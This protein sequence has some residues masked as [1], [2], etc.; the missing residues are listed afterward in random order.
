MTELHNRLQATLGDAF[1]LERELARGGMSRLF[2]ATEASLNRQ[3]VIKVL[4][5]E[6]A[7]DV[8]AARFKQEI[9]LAAQLQHPHILPVLTAG[10]QD[11]LIYY[12]M[13]YVTGESLRHRLTT[14]GKLPVT[15]AARIL[16][17]V[18]DALA[19]AHAHGVVHRD[20]KPEN[21]LL[22]QGHAVLTDFGVARALAEARGEERLTE[23]GL[24]V[25]TPGYMAP[26][27]VA[28]ERHVDARADVYALAVVGY[29][30]LA[31]TPPFTGPTAQAVLAAHLTETPKPLSELRADTPPA[32]TTTIAQALAKDP[33]ERLQTAA[34]FRDVVGT[35][36]GVIAAIAAPRRWL[37]GVAA[38]AVLVLA[39]VFALWPRGW[40]IEG[41]PRKSI[42]VFPFENRTGIADNDWLQEASMN[43]LDLSLAHWEDMRVYDDERTAS[44]MR[45][46]DVASPQDLDFD[47]AQAMAREARVGTLVLGDIRRE[48]DSLVVEAKVHDVASG[49]RLAT[50]IVRSD[51][52]SDPR[53]LF[54]S[55]AARILQVSGAP[56]GERPGVVAQTTRSL[57]AYRAYLAGTD[58]LQRFALDSAEMHLTRAVELD[59]TFA[60]TY[61]QLRNVEGWR[62]A[63]GDPAKR[64]ALV[65][66]AAA[67]SQALPSRLR[68]L[69]QAYAAFEN[70]QLRRSRSIAEQLIAR[71]PAD[72]EAWYQLGEAHY[73]DRSQEFPHP[74]T[75]GNVGKALHAFQRALALDSNY[76]LA[77]QHILD[78]L[79][80]CADAGASY[81]CFADSALYAEPAALRARFGAETVER[82]RRQAEEERV[83]TAYGW[84]SA[85]PSS[86][87]AREGLIRLLLDRERFDEAAN[88]STILKDLGLESQ[89]LA[90]EARA[91]FA[92]R[93]FSEAADRMTESTATLSDAELDA[94]M[95]DAYGNAFVIVGAAGRVDKAR[96]LM[97]RWIRAIPVDAIPVTGP[98][99][100][101]AMLP[102]AIIG[103]LIDIVL[104][105]Y[106]V[107]SV[108]ISRAAHEWLDLLQSTLA[109]DTAAYRI[110]M[111]APDFAML[112]SYLWSRDTTILTHFLSYQDADT[113]HSGRA[114]L[115]LARGDTAE[116]RDIV[117][118]RFRPDESR[119]AGWSGAESKEGY[120]WADLLA[121]LGDLREAVDAYAQLDSIHLDAGV[122]LMIRSWAERGALYQELGERRQAIEMYQKFID[123]LEDGD[124]TVQPM[125]ERAR[126]ALA[127]LRGEA[128]PP[129]DR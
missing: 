97:T 39:G 37:W 113:W 79:S 109:P 15:D 1:R 92:Q 49:D 74:D 122:T 3:V 58:A 65:A 25:G 85:A 87:R 72:V 64:R 86:I 2:L 44:L 71:D 36:S 4:P 125:V 18:S 27:Q 123:A 106:H 124:E 9:E 91:L 108:E 98:E 77:Y 112:T 38:A 24:A 32:I 26:E 67:H 70:N 5:P 21:I 63:A 127:A 76:V 28:G 54:D 6:M 120:A 116:A 114:H 119:P 80:N 102:T 121:R 47:A 62:T 128:Y 48:R 111:T 55:V 81:L 110:I 105:E 34:E 99:G 84:V 17:E 30:M 57:D 82:L 40:S 13:P 95:F 51:L 50:E 93:R 60:L 100:D 20:I 83:A 73:H 19:Y 118:R 52:A 117:E 35:P 90:Y 56:A 78:A 14:E 104:A 45:R 107:D 29:E 96:E 8:S 7:N 126:R 66:K 75:V 11:D 61:I 10:A 101:V 12:V 43:L 42:I 89:A 94:Q 88:Q 53:L 33:A 16:Y 115:A 69:I 68:S 22:E 59:S 41:D 129:V 103:E 31:G 23:T 46:R